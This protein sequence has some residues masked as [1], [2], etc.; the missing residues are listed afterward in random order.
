[1]SSE[2]SDAS[3]QAIF[4]KGLFRS[5]P[6]FLMRSRQAPYEQSLVKAVKALESMSPEG[7]AEEK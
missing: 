6:I 1:M 2:M 7:G 5:G 3:P 4:D